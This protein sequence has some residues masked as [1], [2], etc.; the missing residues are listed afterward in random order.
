MSDKVFQID[1]ESIDGMS[2]EQA[3]RK[4]EDIV[5]ELESGEQS[6]EEAVRLFELGQELLR[7]CNRLLDQAELKLRKITGENFEDLNLEG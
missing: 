5:L 4:L 3:H 2:Y 1:D 7:H 6:L